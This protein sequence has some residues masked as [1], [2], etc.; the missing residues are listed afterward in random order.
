M[1][2]ESPF[3]STETR[4]TGTIAANRGNAAPNGEEKCKK[5]HHSHPDSDQSIGIV[6]WRFTVKV[7]IVEPGNKIAQWD[8][9]EDS[10]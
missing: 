8:A 5:S 1:S 6:V 2:I 4:T 10:E 3:S 7:L 9:E